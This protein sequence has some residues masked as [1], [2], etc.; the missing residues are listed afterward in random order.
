MITA[1]KKGLAS[2][3]IIAAISA[4]SIGALVTTVKNTSIKN[5]N[6]KIQDYN[7]KNKTKRYMADQVIKNLGPEEDRMKADLSDIEKELECIQHLIDTGNEN[8]I[9]ENAARNL[10]ETR[11]SLNRNIC[12]IQ[13][14]KRDKESLVDMDEIPLIQNFYTM[15][16]G[17]LN[18]AANALQSGLLKMRRPAKN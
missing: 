5:T 10:R 11:R 6:K 15:L 13:N 12:A 17:K 4:F 14:A 2:G 16:A 8:L 3:S 9:P 7:M 1:H 18:Q